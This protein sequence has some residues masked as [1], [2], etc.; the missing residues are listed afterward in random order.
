LVPAL[1]HHVHLLLVSLYYPP[2]Q[3]QAR[4]N[5][6]FVCVPTNRQTNKFLLGIPIEGKAQYS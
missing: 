3:T 1:L 6:P 5:A 2:F 4:M